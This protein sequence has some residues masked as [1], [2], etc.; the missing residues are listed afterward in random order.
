M[1][2]L[3]FNQNDLRAVIE[4]REKRIY[5][6]I[7]EMPENKL[8]NTPADDLINYFDQEYSFEA[9]QL[10]EAEIQA[11][12]GDAK[13][14][15]SG[16]SRYATW[17]S[18]R[19]TYVNGT[20]ITFYVPFKGDKEL[21]KCRPSTFTFNPPRA[22]IRDN[23]LVFQYQKTSAET[24]QIKAEFDGELK[25]TRQYLTWV[26]QDIKQFNASLKDKVQGR[27]E[28]R[29]QKLLKDRG[30]VEKIGFPLRRREGTA[31]TYV[32]PQVKRKVSPSMPQSST[33]AFVPEPSLDVAEYEHILSVIGNM[34]LVMERSPHAFKD[35]K[36]EDLRQH[37]LVQLNGQYEGQA[38]GET[39][40][41]QGKTDILI[42]VDGKNI[43][44]AE[45]KFWSGPEKLREAL[46][47]L[48]GYATWRDSKL[49]LLIFNRERALSTVLTK[50]PEIVKSHK[51][52]KRQL[53]YKSET[54]FR[55]IFEHPGDSSKEL[56][57]TCLVF[58]VPA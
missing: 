45:C 39:F 29:K 12:Y 44:V 48:L 3:L 28:N 50:I 26:V 19:P 23:E 36:E 41:Y 4:A 57:L 20:Q 55:F 15:V 6:Q 53:E 11:D 13:I 2:D 5:Q 30:L 34:V 31:Q 14:D 51:H 46:D 1:L 56:T 27:L 18:G 35:M 38:T 8:L 21:F 7:D 32:A 43:F 47:Q 25:E 9:P 54:G 52:F 37:F 40:N 16:R 49:A 22:D 24:E 42:R 58:D 17:D 33:K 10:N